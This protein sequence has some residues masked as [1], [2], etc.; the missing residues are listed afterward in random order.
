M[1]AAGRLRRRC[2][3][4]RGGSA[5]AKGIAVADFDGDGREDVA[6]LLPT[7]GKAMVVTRLAFTPPTLCGRQ[8]ARIARRCSIVP[9]TLEVTLEQRELSFGAFTP[10]VAKTYSK[11]LAAT[12]RSSVDAVTITFE[13][14]IG[15]DEILHAGTY[16]AAVTFTVAATTP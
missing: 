8:M 5:P 2:V 6:T 14:R 13:Q 9:P 4:R 3:Q 15:A 7:A 11:T 10:G 12:V 16:S 1:G